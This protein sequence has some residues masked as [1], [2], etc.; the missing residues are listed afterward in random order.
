MQDQNVKNPPQ[1]AELP[2][3]GVPM[4]LK[5]MEIG[6]IET[7]YFV[8]LKRVAS[9]RVMLSNIKTYTDKVFET[10][11]VDDNSGDIILWRKS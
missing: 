10:Q 8:P 9:I 11:Q 5:E 1:W 4:I 7:G 3:T 6:T 2:E